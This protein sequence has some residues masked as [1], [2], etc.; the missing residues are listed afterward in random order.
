LGVLPQE[1]DDIPV[2]HPRRYRDELF[3]IHHDPDKW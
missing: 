3:T 2:F 1:L